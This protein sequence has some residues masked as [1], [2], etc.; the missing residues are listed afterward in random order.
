MAEP[1]SVL[2]VLVEKRW[3]VL[4]W[5]GVRGDLQVRGLVFEPNRCADT[6]RVPWRPRCF[7]LVLY[8]N[9]YE[10]NVYF[11][12]LNC[13]TTGVWNVVVG[14]RGVGTFRRN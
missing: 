9:E 11:P 1:I 6:W 12:S 5:L 14:M 10:S 4:R 13:C 3:E 2:L 8:L 7:D